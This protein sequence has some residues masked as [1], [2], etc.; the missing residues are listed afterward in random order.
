MTFIYDD[1]P[2]SAG[3]SFLP[4]KANLK[5]MVVSCGNLDKQIALINDDKE[6]YGLL[7]GETYCYDMPVRCPMRLSSSV[8]IKVRRRFS[9]GFRRSLV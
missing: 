5:A 1:L 6:T 3:G 2:S 7:T 9:Y 4:L 8:I